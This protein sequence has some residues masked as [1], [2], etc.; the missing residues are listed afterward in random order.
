MTSDDQTKYTI[1]FETTTEVVADSEDDAL[2]EAENAFGHSRAA[3]EVTDREPIS[4]IDGAYIKA[5]FHPQ[6]W[7]GDRAVRADRRGKETWFVPLEDA[8]T[9]DGV[10]P[11]DNSYA[12]DGLRSHDRAPL[13]VK[14]WDGPFY[15]TIE[16]VNDLPEGETPADYYPD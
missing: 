10:L 6:R 12:S 3:L 9:D 13:W 11:E 1:R 7:S 8:L 15:V 14:Q 5:R 2:R 4:G 16:E